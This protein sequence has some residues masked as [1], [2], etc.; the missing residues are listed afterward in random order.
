MQ[1]FDSID[2]H[3]MI[4]TITW[5]DDDGEIDTEIPIEFVVCERCDGKGAHCNPNID[6][7][8]LTSEDFEQDPDFEESY[9]R[10]DYDVRCHECH[11]AN[12]T[13]DVASN[14]VLT[15]EQ[16]EAIAFKV[17]GHIADAEDRRTQRMENGDY[18]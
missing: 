9:F 16:K 15:E 5:E 4:G 2:K 8:G 6:G 12:V 1:L 18:E 14:H 7:N 13:P 11:G 10:G 3:R 17:A